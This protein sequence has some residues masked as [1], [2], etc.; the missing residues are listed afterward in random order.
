[1]TNKIPTVCFAVI[2]LTALSLILIDGWYNDGIYPPTCSEDCRGD[3]LLSRFHCTCLVSV[4]DEIKRETCTLLTNYYKNNTFT[5]SSS[6]SHDC[7]D[8]YSPDWCKNRHACIGGR[9]TCPT[10]EV[11]ERHYNR[12]DD[13]ASMFYC[14]SVNLTFCNCSLMSN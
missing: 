6:S 3:Y 8:F 2:I 12:G 4:P 7:Y 13:I 10:F 1:M 14:E 9:N 5:G 11:A